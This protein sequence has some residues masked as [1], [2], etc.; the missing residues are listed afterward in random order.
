M[1]KGYWVGQVKEIKN[2]EK[3]GQY[4]EKFMNIVAEEAEKKSGNFVPTASSEPKFYVQKNFDLLYSAVV[5]FN[6][7]QDAIDGYND[8]RYQEALAHLGE[9]K[10][11]V[12]VRNLVIIEGN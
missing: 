6:S 1:K 9:N 2:E 3:W 5:E 12:V 10:E 8:P 4:L 11:D 7:V